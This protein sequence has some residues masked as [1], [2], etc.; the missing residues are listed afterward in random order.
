MHI[1]CIL[2]PST[3]HKRYEFTKSK[4]GVHLKPEVSRKG[5]AMIW[6]HRHFAKEF[7][8]FTL[9]FYF[10]KELYLE[11]LQLFLKWLFFW[12]IGP[13]IAFH[14]KCYLYQRRW[15]GAHARLFW[16]CGTTLS[17]LPYFHYIRLIRAMSMSLLFFSKKKNW[18]LKFTGALENVH[19]T[20]HMVRPFRKTSGFGCTV[21]FDF[22]SLY[23]RCLVDDL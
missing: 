23:L 21:N 4:F 14:P 2:K 8:T 17:F 1:P 16:R 11:M 10:W 13:C 18:K 6:Y 20:N 3:K 12:G 19:D 15:Q 5:L 22:A 7:S 9:S